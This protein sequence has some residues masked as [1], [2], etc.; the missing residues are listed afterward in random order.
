MN[1]PDPIAAIIALRY[2]CTF[3][4]RPVAF[5]ASSKGATSDAGIVAHRDHYRPT[6]R[7][8]TAMLTVTVGEADACRVRRALCYCGPNSVEFVKLTRVPRGNRV[9]LQIA[10]KAEA[11]SEAMSKIIS[12]VDEA[13]FGR[14]TVIPN[15]SRIRGIQRVLHRWKGAFSQLPQG[16]LKRGSLG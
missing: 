15:H 4:P 9:R 6:A 5:A 14:T 1:S 13:E 12:S 11:A 3:T 8:G 7:R 10:L 2:V 16:Q